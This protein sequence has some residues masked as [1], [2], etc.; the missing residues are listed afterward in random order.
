MTLQANHLLQHVHKSIKDLPAESP[1]KT[2]GSK[3]SAQVFYDECYTAVH[4][5]LTEILDYISEP[6][7]GS[8]FFS[9]LL[10]V[11]ENKPKHEKEAVFY[12]WDKQVYRKFGASFLPIY[13]AT[14]APEDILNDAGYGVKSFFIQTVIPAYK[15]LSALLPK[16]HGQDN[17]VEK[18]YMY[19]HALLQV[20]A[21]ELM[22]LPANV[23]ETKEYRENRD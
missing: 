11:E 10:F 1:K 13:K 6:I 20:L 5:P 9:I 7:E 3:R 2:G 15:S 12:G 14:K 23:E 16:N 18:Q 4:K 22:D 8:D 21:I 17:L 19:F